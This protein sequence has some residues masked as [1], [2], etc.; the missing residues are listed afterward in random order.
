MSK[1]VH[2]V[3][4]AN[5]LMKMTLPF[6]CKSKHTFLTHCVCMFGHD[7]VPTSHSPCLYGFVCKLHTF[8]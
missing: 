5:D 4:S 2:V 3:R 7:V 8:N 1:H 6:L